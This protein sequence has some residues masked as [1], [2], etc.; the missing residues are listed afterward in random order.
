[1]ITKTSIAVAAFQRG[2]FKEALRIAHGF[3]AGLSNAERAALRDG[4]EAMVHPAFYQSIGKHPA[5][6]V[7]EA[8]IV[9]HDCILTPHER[10][11][12]AV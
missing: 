5:H 1:M 3:R 12:E 7:N 2:D 6:Y 10:A 8:Q 4:Y 9:F 11:K